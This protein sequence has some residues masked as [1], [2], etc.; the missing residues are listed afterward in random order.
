MTA[1][2]DSGK[3]PVGRVVVIEEHQTY[4]DRDGYCWEA[5]LRR[6]GEGLDVDLPEMLVDVIVVSLAKNHQTRC[7][8]GSCSP[9]ANELNLRP[10]SR[11]V[12]PLLSMMTVFQGCDLSSSIVGGLYSKRTWVIPSGTRAFE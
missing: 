8:T 2:E 5:T 6:T 9:D 3:G 4:I 12:G 7:F 10:Y 1:N 11:H